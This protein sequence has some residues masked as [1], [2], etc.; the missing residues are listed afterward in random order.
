MRS[1][2]ALRA[3][4][5][6][7]SVGFILAVTSGFVL[8]WLGVARFPLARDRAAR[9]AVRRRGACRWCAS[10]HTEASAAGALTLAHGLP[11]AWFF[12][13]LLHRPRA[14]A[15]TFFSL[16]RLARLRHRH[17]RP[18]VGAVGGRRGCSGSGSRAAGTPLVD[19]RLV[20]AGRNRDDAASRRRRRSAT[21]RGARARAQYGSPSR[22]STACIGSSTATSRA[23]CAGAAGALLPCSATRSIRRGQQG[24]P[25]AQLGPVEA[26]VFWAACAAGVL[27]RRLERPA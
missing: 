15:S 22:R 26:A 9:S 25:A 18:D 2:P 20:A 19:A 5:R 27:A 6:G 3:R 13:R 8:Q 17:G 21:S 10:R 1:T 11:V 14:P 7:D 4:A 23:G 24:S 12:A 16:A